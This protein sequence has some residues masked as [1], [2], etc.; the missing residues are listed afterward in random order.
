MKRSGCEMR[1]LGP[2]GRAAALLTMVFLS[3]CAE[4][5]PEETERV[6][7]IKPYFVV[8]PAGSD[9][10]R[11]AGTV[12]ASNTSAL[13]FAVDGTV[14]TVDVAQG[15]RVVRGQVLATLDAAPFNLSLEGARSEL[16]SAQ[17]DY[18]NQKLEL[19]RQRQLYE[20]EWVAKAAYD[21]AVAGFEAAEGQLSLSRSRLGLAERDVAH[22]RLMAP[23]DGV[24]SMRDVDPF[25]EIRKGEPVFQIDSDGALDVEMSI[26]DSVVGR[27]AIG[28]PVTVQA[29][30]VNG[31]GCTGRITEIGSAAGTANTVP[32]TATILE[33]PDGLLPGTAVDVSVALS[34]TEG[35]GPRGFMVPLVA[36]A[37]GDGETQGYVFKYDEA[38][39]VVR[40]TPVSGDGPVS[41]NLISVSQ[42]VEA[43]DIIA[44]AGVS[45]L[46]D[47]QRVRLM[48]Q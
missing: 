16:A 44:A 7:A 4:A 33:R 41:G 1:R 28:A 20:R 39:G 5:P 21:K 31:C 27:L 43:G 18:D 2:A 47:G 12:Q 10:R 23:F 42:G 19:D 29:T 22:T 45:F 36:I 15:D 25:V 17:A 3:S 48:G 40:R 6:R 14:Q 24:I 37:P 38:G 34:G 32:V 13:S 35:E 9:M 8:E 30:T 46:R 26:P 11:Y